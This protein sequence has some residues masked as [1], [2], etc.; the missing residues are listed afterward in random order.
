MHTTEWLD[1]LTT[2]WH[3]TSIWEIIAVVFSISGV[4]LAYRNSVWLYPVGLVA[5][6]IYTVLMASPKVGLYA[7]AALNLYYF[8]MSV[9]GW[10]LWGRHRNEAKELPITHSSR[11]D[12]ITVAGICVGGFLLL[13]LVL[14]NYTPST[15]PVMDAIVS[16][17]AWSGMWLLAKRKVE[18]WLML[19][20][21]NA[22]AIP[23]LFFKQMPLTALL[24]LF[25]FTVALFGYANWH[26]ISRQSKHNTGKVVNLR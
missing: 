19:N 14:K 2:Q 22:V 10:L 9:Y 11:S 15:V 18:N 20:V 12:W 26:R 3:H 17:T 13:Y 16:A 4:L 7:D 25:L 8:V 23:L 1:L 6:G 5:T 21:S 24:T